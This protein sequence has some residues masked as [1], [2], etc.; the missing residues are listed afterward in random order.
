ME[1]WSDLVNG[2]GLKLMTIPA[3]ATNTTTL[4]ITSYLKDQ[5]RFM[6]IGQK[7]TMGDPGI[8]ME[9]KC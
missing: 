5:Q 6:R 1:G 8:A 4:K 3:A 2:A 9:G 7:F